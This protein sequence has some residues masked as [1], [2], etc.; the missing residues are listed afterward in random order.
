MSIMQVYQ[1]DLLKEID[2]GGEFSADALREL[3]WATDLSLRATK[4]MVG[5]Q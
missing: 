2:E 3:R 5:N 4:E 1:A